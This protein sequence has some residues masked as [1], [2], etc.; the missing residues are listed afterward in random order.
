MQQHTGEHLAVFARVPVLG[1]VKTRL[2]REIGEAA[3]LEAYRRLLEYA[4]VALQPR[5]WRASLF[6]DAPGLEA[7]A[8]RFG[9]TSRRQHGSQLGMRMANAMQELLQADSRVALVG[10]DI[11]LLDADYVSEAFALLREADLVL[12][13]TE[14]GGYCLIAMKEPHPALFEGIAWGAAHVCAGTL[15]KAEALN[16][17]VR[18]MKTLWD[19]D[20][21]ADLAR[22]QSLGMC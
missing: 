14:D 13:P 3:A 2:A 6:A 11:P 9:M 1:R 17:G 21:A 5:Q 8:R 15:A 10:V 7:L 19:V 22:W 18:T 4:L 16:L 12:G 20:T